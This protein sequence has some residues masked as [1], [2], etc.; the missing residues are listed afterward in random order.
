L[1]VKACGISYLLENFLIIKYDT[2]TYFIKDL[3]ELQAGKEV[4][5]LY[6]LPPVPPAVGYAKMGGQMIWIE[7]NAGEYCVPNQVLTGQDKPLFRKVNN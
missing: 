3:E 4:D 7:Y 5:L 6:L 2:G 1:T